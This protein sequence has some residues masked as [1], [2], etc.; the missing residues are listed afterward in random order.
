MTGLAG[1]TTRA[2]RPVSPASAAVFRIGF[3]LGGV[4]LVARFLAK[5]WVETLFLEPAYH[6]PYPGFEWVKVWPGWGMYAH[7][8]LIGLAAVG[9]LLGFRTRICALVFA[10]LLA[11]VELIDRTLYLNHYYWVILTAAVLAFLPVDRAF[12]LDSRRDRVPGQWIPAWVIW[13]LRF[14]VGMVYFFAGLAKLNA[15]WLIHGEPMATW[16]P[17]RSGLPLIGP[18]LALPATALVASWLGAFFDLTI[19]FWLLNRRTRL[20]A[21]VVVAMFHTAT[22][23]LFPS[24]GLFPLLMTMSALIFFEPDWPARFT[25]RRRVAQPEKE[26]TIHRP[27][28]GLVVLYLAVM[29]ALPLRHYLVPGDVKWTGEGY[30][31]SWQVML[32]E[33]SGSA[34]FVVTDPKTGDTWRVPPPSYLTPRQEVVMATDPIMIKE[35]ADLISEDLGGVEV[36]ADV[37]LSFNGRPSTQFTNPSV[38]LT[39]VDFGDAARDWLE[40]EPGY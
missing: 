11:Y 34:T 30:L 10:M 12:S 20:A 3:G 28:L 27:W 23:V 21:F 38:D 26:F 36:A 25:R 40:P 16:L 18:M 39:T 6:F 19:V 2:R 37:V 9:I 8:A 22:W 31:G 1:V 13:L 15:D 4:I 5:G 7:F 32:S 35:T 17:G 33:K 29:V 24:I 14:Q